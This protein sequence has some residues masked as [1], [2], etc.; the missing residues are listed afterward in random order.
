MDS[1]ERRWFMG[2]S[3]DRDWEGNW[4]RMMVYLVIR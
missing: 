4:H 1:G 3:Q 2:T